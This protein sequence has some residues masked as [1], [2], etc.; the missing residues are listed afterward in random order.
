M[1]FKYIAVPAGTNECPIPCRVHITQR[2]EQMWA[3]C[4]CPRLT[5]TLQPSGAE[6]EA[7]ARRPP[8]GPPLSI[9]SSGRRGAGGRP[10]PPG[11][12]GA[13]AAPSR[14]GR[15][16]LREPAVPGPGRARV[17]GG[18]GA[19]RPLPFSAPRGGRAGV[20]P[21]QALSANPG[22]SQ[23]VPQSIRRDGLGRV[24][25]RIRLRG[26]RRGAAPS[27]SVGAARSWGSALGC[28]ARAANAAGGRSPGG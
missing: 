26:R 13:A 11:P 27:A 2:V 1:T 19:Q 18:R 9:A 10:G 4:P 7:G 24:L 20:P 23:P 25:R 17:R 28:G 8:A 5:R 15:R 12:S 14:R 3:A 22:G 6:G 21:G 16:R